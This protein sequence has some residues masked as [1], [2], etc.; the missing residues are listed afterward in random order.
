MDMKTLILFA[1]CLVM[2][3]NVFGKMKTE[4]YFVE[5]IADDHKKITQ[6]MERIIK[7]NPKII[8]NGFH[9]VRIVQHIEGNLYLASRGLGPASLAVRFPEVNKTLADES[10]I[11]GYFLDSGETYAY[12]TVLG[13]KKTVRLGEFRSSKYPFENVE[14][15]KKSVQGGC[16]FRISSQDQCAEC[17]GLG[18]IQN[19]RFRKLAKKTERGEEYISCNICDRRGKVFNELLIIW[20]KD[21]A[22]P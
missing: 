3:S 4:T 12:K 10:I 17:K 9:A 8:E 6:I 5:P 20:N 22:Y 13:A 1:A 7:G 16:W 2:T 15:F 18:K 14:Q 19:P 11:K 21:T